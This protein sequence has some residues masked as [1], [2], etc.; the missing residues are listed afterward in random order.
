MFEIKIDSSEIKALAGRFPQW[1]KRATKS[2]LSSTGYFLKQEIRRQGIMG[3]G[4]LGWRPLSPYTGT[5]G[6]A[7]G[8]DGTRKQ[9]SRYKRDKR[10]YLQNESGQR[11]HKVWKSTRRAPM[12][13]LTGAVRY[14]VFLSQG[15][16]RIG[17]LDSKMARLARIQ[18][19]GFTTTISARMRRLFFALHLPLV[20]GSS[21]IV[22]PPRPWVGKV[23]E[24]K[25]QAAIEHFRQK[26]VA[27]ISRYRSGG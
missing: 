27:N 2:A 13:K 21:Q 11:M 14:K 15:V 6:R 20:A 7:H 17:F 22:T 5:L 8:K 18:A 19:K 23:A 1:V 25:K 16:V 4:M 26:F 3:I 10:N 9:L 12:G 24:Q